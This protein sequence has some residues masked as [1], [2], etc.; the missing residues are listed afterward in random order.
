M[1]AG[2]C[3]KFSFRVTDSAGP[4]YELAGNRSV[5]KHNPLSFHE[6]WA[7]SWANEVEFGFA[8]E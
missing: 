1:Q 3:V 6:Y 7:Q 5:S 4:S 2:K 8:K